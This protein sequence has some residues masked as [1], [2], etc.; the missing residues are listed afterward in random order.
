ML[1]MTVRARAAASLSHQRHLTRRLTSHVRARS[2]S[3]WLTDVNFAMEYVRLPVEGKAKIPVRDWLVPGM[4]PEGVKT[5]KC[6][7]CVQWEAQ[8]E[9]EMLQDFNYFYYPWDEQKVKITFEVEG[10]DLY[11][12]DNQNGLFGEDGARLA[13]ELERKEDEP[14]PQSLLIGS[15]EWLLTDQHDWRPS[16]SLAKARNAATGEEEAHKCELTIS[17]RR[18]PI[19]FMVRGIFSTILVVSGCAADA[20]TCLWLHACRVHNARVPAC[21]TCRLHADRLLARCYCTPRNTLATVRPSSSLRFSFSSPICKWTS[22]SVRFRVC[23]GSTHLTS[24]S[25]SSWC[26]ASLRRWHATQCFTTL[27]ETGQRQLF[28]WITSHGA[29]LVFCTSSLHSLSA[30]KARTGAFGPLA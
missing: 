27:I 17:V 23:F 18:I 19:A 26:C 12:C 11:T 29:C 4:K 9:Y 6:E 7:Y 16:V 22:A 8:V 2:C 10:A 3:C 30:L 1:G 21:C 15:A 20:R 25:Y 13:N 28:T 5:Q 14:S 24:C